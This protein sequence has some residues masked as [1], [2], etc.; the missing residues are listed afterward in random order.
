MKEGLS[1]TFLFLSFFSKIHVSPVKDQVIQLV[2][3]IFSK[4]SWDSLAE[5]FS[6]ASAAAALSN[7]RFHVPVLV[8]TQGPATVSHSQPT[9]QVELAR[10]KSRLSS[11][12]SFWTHII[13]DSQLLITDVLSR[14]LRSA[15]VLLES[16]HA[17]PSKSVVLSQEPFTLKKYVC[18]KLKSSCLLLGFFGIATSDMIKT[19]FSV[20]SDV[21]ELNFMAKQPPSGYYQFSVAVAG[22]SRLV[23]NQV[24]VRSP[25]LQPQSQPPLLGGSVVSVDKKCQTCM[26]LTSTHEV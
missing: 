15:N 7:N 13:S 10:R 12:L 16:A 21:F 25:L 9:L 14:P 18:G 23:A 20:H 1:L 2:N 8:N 22:D 3:S 19:S 17:V 5:A 6:V 11:P 26:S 24:E 4:K